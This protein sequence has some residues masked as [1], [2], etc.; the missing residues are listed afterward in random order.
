[1]T[2]SLSIVGALALLALA[3]P[4][5][6]QVVNPTKV[7]FVA[8]SDH[9]LVVNGTAVVTGYQLDVMV[10]A[11]TGAL[12][13]SSNIGKPTPG[14]NSLISVIVPQ[15]SALTNGVFVATVSALGPGGSGKSTP[16]APFG[17]IG[18]PTAPTGVVVGP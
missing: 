4:A 14:A 13:F 16:S 8:S 12:A 1:M 11:P 18:Q 2:R 3:S 6:A 9:A 5:Q 17:R 7:E 15:L 10:S